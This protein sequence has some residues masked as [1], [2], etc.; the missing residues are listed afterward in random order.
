MVAPAPTSAPTPLTLTI[1]DKPSDMGIKPITD[2]D[3]WTK[4]TKIIDTRLR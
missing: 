3:Y 1:K 2:K 4:A